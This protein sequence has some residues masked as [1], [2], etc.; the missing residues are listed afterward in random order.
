M[1]SVIRR[2][3]KAVGGLMLMVLLLCSGTTDLLASP[4]LK[5]KLVFIDSRV[6][7][8]EVLAHEWTGQAEVHLVG[9]DADGFETVR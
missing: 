6:A 8:S 4:L 2:F 3:L 9:Q 5:R 7:H 1:G